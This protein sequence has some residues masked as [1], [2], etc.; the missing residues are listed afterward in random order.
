MAS[1]DDGQKSEQPTQRKRDEARRQGQ[2]AY[3][4]E[5][6]GTMLLMAA[7]LLM[8]LYGEDFTSQLRSA[9][10]TYLA[11]SHA[12]VHDYVGPMDVLKDAIS[13]GLGVAGGFMAVMFA[14]AL[15]VNFA[16]VGFLFSTE[17][18]EFKW[19]KLDPISGFMKIVSVMGIVK[20]LQQVLKTAA[21]GCI[22]MWLLWGREHSIAAL[23]DAPLL[24]SA[25]Q[26]WHIALQLL[27]AVTAMLMLLAAGDY[28]YQW[29]RME[30]ELK[31][32]KQEVKD[33]HR[34]EEGDPHVRARR[35]QIQRELAQKRKMIRDVPKAT[36]VITNPDHFAIALRY[37]RGENSAPI[38]LAKGTDHFALK[39]IAEARK[40]GVAVVERKPLARALYKLVNVGD[41][42]PHTLYVAVSE[43][44][45]YLHRLKHG[46][47][48][49]G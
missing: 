34:N 9:M 35:R 10:E 43:V 47:A 26:V 4:Q 13:R 5:L 36:V 31:M 21:V 49:V 6:T 48:M 46:N 39:I 16:Q 2:V 11:N 8:W 42:I 15:L 22:A 44:L 17:A 3:S 28:F 12:M 14:I 24:Y 45:A 41:E 37:E 20:G 1:E 38:C 29:Y 27:I 33:E 30:N 19:E 23:T 32:T 18:L 25:K 40:H 7:V